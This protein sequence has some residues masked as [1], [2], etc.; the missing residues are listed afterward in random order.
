MG[1]GFLGLLLQDPQNAPLFAQV[2]SLLFVVL[3][4]VPGHLAGAILQAFELLHQ[5]ADA[6]L[7]LD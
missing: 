2:S 5:L 7:V 4:V 3:E 6:G 1:N